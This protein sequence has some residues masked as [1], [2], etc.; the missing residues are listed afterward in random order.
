MAFLVVYLLK[1]EVLNISIPERPGL[2][3]LSLLVLFAGYSADA[4]AWKKILSSEVPGLTFKDAYSGAG[5]YVFTKY[6]PGKVWILLGK[7]G[8]INVKYA[9]PVVVTG[10]L[11]FYYQLASI[12]CASLLGSGLL[13]RINHALFWA[14]LTVIA[15]LALYFFIFQGGTSK[16]IS[17]LGQTVTGRKTE[18]P[19][20]DNAVT[21]KVMLYS[22]VNWIIWSAAFVLFLFS[23][24]SECTVTPAMGL[25]FPASAVIGIVVLIAPGGLVFREGIITAGLLLFG[26]TAPEAASL[27]LFSRIWWLAGELLN[28]ISAVIWLQFK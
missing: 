2:F 8:Y 26:F 1:K 18:L 13:Y 11:S 24:C 7:A 6:I 15:V 27:A 14:S 19:V 3:I 12:F 22:L 10:A 23:V 21:F 17:F 4:M 20:V 25:I 28:F 9:T 5:K 16:M